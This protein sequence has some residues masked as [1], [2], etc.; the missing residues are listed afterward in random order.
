MADIIVVGS[1]IPS[2][3]K[4]AWYY[5]GVGALVITED[6]VVDANGAVEL[7]K[8]AEYGSITCRTAAG[9][10]TATML[11]LTT[12]GTP[13]VAATDATGTSFVDTGEVAATTVTVH[14]LD[15]ATTALAQIIGCKDVNSPLSIDTTET[16]VHNQ[17]QKLQLT[18]A[19]ARTFTAEQ[20]DY[21]MLF[22]G[23]VFGD[24]IANSPAA[25][26]YKFTDKYTS[27]KKLSAVVGKRVEDGVLLKKWV[28]YGLQVTKIDNSH[29][30]ADFYARSMDF[31]VD[32]LT[33]TDIVP[34]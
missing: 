13:D 31:T 30:T 27:V 26:M 5:G 7:S 28:Y 34:N 22:M 8:K 11:E 6:L 3:N 1:D 15:I 32:S 20:V 24:V 33:E 25:G 17:T 2:G 4:I 9:A 10:M 23:A 12:V 21:N 29:P 14:Y 16:E 19:A 18:G